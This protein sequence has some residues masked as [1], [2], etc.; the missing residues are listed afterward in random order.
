MRNEIWLGNNAGN[1]EFTVPEHYEPRATRYWVDDNGQKWRSLG[2][3]CWFTNL[4]YPKRHEPLYLY[5]SY[6]P[7]TY[8][9][10]DNYD[11]V[12]VSK[13]ENIPCDYDG[14]MGVPVTFL[15]KYS[16]E[17]FEIVGEAN[18]GLD[19]SY[20]LFKPTVHG[21][22]VFKRILIKRRPQQ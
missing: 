17:Q 20:D 7:E 9:R 2:N 18:H 21:K 5:K 4:D 16:P 8:P 22:D 3:I 19:S 11:A 10:Y 6:D 15:T 1:M 13:V 12:E 14:V